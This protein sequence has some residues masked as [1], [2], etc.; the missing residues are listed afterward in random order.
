LRNFILPHIPR[1]SSSANPG[2]FPGKIP[3]GLR[4]EYDVRSDSV[5]AG[6]SVFGFAQ[7]AQGTQSYF[8]MQTTL[9]NFAALARGKPKSR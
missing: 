7:R 6:K 1:H 3:R 9:A 5:A 8:K 2:L 4:C